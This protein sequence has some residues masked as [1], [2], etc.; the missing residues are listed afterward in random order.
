MS[1]HDVSD[2]DR[3]GDDADVTQASG[4]GL[5]AALR[6]TWYLWAGAIVAAVLTW[7]AVT[8]QNLGQS[9]FEE[10]LFGT[11][12]VVFLAAGGINVLMEWRV[13]DRVEA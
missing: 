1:G 2:I 4:R 3:A 13:V 8:F 11:L 7:I 10:L 6:E 5:T 12:T 9:F